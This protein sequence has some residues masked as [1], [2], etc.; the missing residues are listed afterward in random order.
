MS[1][2]GSDQDHALI[3]RLGT[4]KPLHVVIIMSLCITRKEFAVFVALARV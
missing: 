2:P 1:I 3:D 4:L